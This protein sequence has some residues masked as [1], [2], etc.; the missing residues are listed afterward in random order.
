LLGLLGGFL[1][2]LKFRILLDLKKLTFIQLPQLL[3]GGISNMVFKHF[4][5][6][7][8]LEDSPDDFTQLFQVLSHFDMG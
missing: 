5:D 6:L 1:V 4:K 7:F 3:V 2:S 8:D